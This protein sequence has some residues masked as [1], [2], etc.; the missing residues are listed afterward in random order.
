MA[1]Y[2]TV[3]YEEKNGV[4]WVTLNRPEANNSFN[5]QMQDELKAIWQSLRFNSDVRCVVLTG[6]GDHAF[7]TGIDRSFIGDWTGPPD[8]PFTWEDPSP[9][10]CPKTNSLWTPVIAAVNGM[11]CAGAFYMLGEVEFAIASETATFFDPHVS[12]GMVA[13][14]ES[15]QLMRKAPFQEVMRM[16][17]L[18]NNERMSAERAREI[19]LISQVVPADQLIESA[20]WAAERIAELPALAIQGTVRAMWM[21]LENSRRAALDMAGLVVRLGTDYDNIREGQRTFQRHDF[22]TPRIR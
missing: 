22:P 16:A 2:E 15:L 21:G 3:L 20:R 9:K 14:I 4:A 18:G 19:G 12:Y 8:N 5:T 1:N 6:A 7:C 10:I 17:L 13:A 11:A